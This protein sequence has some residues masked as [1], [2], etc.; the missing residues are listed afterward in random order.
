MVTKSLQRSRA[1]YQVVVCTIA[2]IVE[3]TQHCPPAAL[4]NQNV[5][6]IDVMMKHL[7]VCRCN[8]VSISDAA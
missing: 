3:A 8:T 6:G 5:A 4:V 2:R 1:V 7:L